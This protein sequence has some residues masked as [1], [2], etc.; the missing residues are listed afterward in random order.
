[1]RVRYSFSSRHTGTLDQHNQHRKEFPELVREFVEKADIILE[2]LDSKFPKETRN[3]EM[4]HIIKG[5]GKKLI[6]ILNKTDLVNPKELKKT[7]ELEL[8]DL[9][10]FVLVS[11]QTRRGSGELRDRIKIEAKSL[12]KD[13][14]Y[15]EGWD[16]DVIVAVIGYPNT[17]KSSVINLL[18]G[19]SSAKTAREAGFTKGVQK[20][21]LAEGIVLLD[22]PG[23]IRENETTEEYGK[24]KLARIGVKTFDKVKDPEIVVQQLMKE[25]PGVVEKFYNIPAEGDSDSL[26]EEIGKRNNFLVKGG[27]VDI[28]RSAKLIIKDWQDGKIRT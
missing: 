19:R 13:K 18:V 12:A 14:K 17:G 15:K 4:E 26:I 1:M 23:V 20:I 2:V 28:N 27:Q 7:L 25:Y 3:L 21:R 8:L 9:K 10:P 5:Y 6:Y 22:T 24:M 11:C 16:R